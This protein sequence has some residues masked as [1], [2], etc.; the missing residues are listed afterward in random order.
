MDCITYRNSGELSDIIVVIDGEEFHLHKFP[1]YVR[2]N[3]FKNLSQASTN[4]TTND[5]SS[6]SRVVL[7]N[8][9]GGKRTFAIIADYCYNKSVQIN[10]DNV[11]AVRCA[12]EYLEMTNGY[13]RS[14]LSTLTDN[15]LFDLT[16]SYKSK[17]DYN[18]SLTLLERAAEF[19]SLAEQAVIHTKLIESFVENLNGYVRKSSIYENSL[20]IYEKSFGI[21]NKA[22]HLN[23][24]TLH[25]LSL[26]NDNI[27][28][29][30]HLP[31]KWMNDLVRISSRY[32]LNQSL[33][34]FIIQ[35]Y[36]DYNTKINPN[37]KLEA[38]ETSSAK[39]KN[40][41]SMAADIINVENKLNS[42]LNHSK[43]DDPLASMKAA[44][45]L[46][47]I[48]NDVRNA[49]G[50]QLDEPQTSNLTLIATQIR[51]PEKPKTS[52]LTQIASEIKVSEPKVGFLT[53]I[54]TEV[55]KVDD[56]DDKPTAFLTQI[57]SEVRGD[58][59]EEPKTANLTH[60][61]SE[62]REPV[63][64]E[65]SSL[66][67]IASEAR[68]PDSEANTLNLINITGDLL[69]VA[70]KLDEIKDD[71][72]R[73]SSDPM[74]SLNMVI[75]LMNLANNDDEEKV[76]AS[77]LISIA[78]QV[79]SNENKPSNN[80]INIASDIRGQPSTSNLKNIAGEVRDGDKHSH[81]KQ[82]DEELASYI[83]YRNNLRDL[84][85][86]NGA[87]DQDKLNVISLLT[88]TL[89]DM[90]I[91][92][93]FP[94]SWLLLYTNALHQMN[95]DAVTMAAFNKWLWASIGDL[96]NNPQELSKIPPPVMIQLTHDVSK[97]NLVD[98]RKVSSFEFFFVGVLWFLVQFYFFNKK[99]I[100]HF[101]TQSRMRY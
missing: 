32:G 87:S 92:P 37:Y 35:N 34:S 31:L 62:I 11:I 33:L 50:K 13:G 12:A 66:T 17:R 41:V 19:A 5:E 40:L 52:S 18:A 25:R 82:P 79:R 14:G 55:R 71:E 43:N 46:I 99:L 38:E 70:S 6:V 77:N 81:Q 89:V 67:K 23:N 95:G 45:N 63:K 90:R 80:L 54:A 44:I 16:Y 8:F 83:R 101:L 72:Q 97:N 53:A 49:G 91:E 93:N 73:T 27:D 86:K 24:V 100:P 3:Y 28:A 29:L 74:S 4:T 1:L 98:K 96:K 76:S 39:S 65:T 26:S 84:L 69:K 61:A 15:I 58:E 60:I 51:E 75:G 47:S 94:I 36:V 10:A 56:D 42:L 9:P 20:S 48:A 21:N 22:S 7:N 64:A 85:N 68:N 2:S 59:E 88:N 30:N 78:E 57:A